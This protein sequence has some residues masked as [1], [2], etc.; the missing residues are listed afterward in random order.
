MKFIFGIV[1]VLF[2]L[3]PI[4]AS[5]DSLPELTSY[6]KQEIANSSHALHAPLESTADPSDAFFFRRWFVRLQ[7]TVGIDVP[8]IASFQIV[9]E[10]ELVWQRAYPEGWADYRPHLAPR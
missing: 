7:A 2:A 1:V 6:L 4:R 3:A 9:P 8:W 5:A 10:V